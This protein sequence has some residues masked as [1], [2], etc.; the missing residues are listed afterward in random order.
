MR[1]AISQFR[2]AIQSAGL[3]P[4]DMIEPGKFHKFPG[5]GKRNGNTAAWCKLFP[6]GIG[7][8]YGDYSTGLSTDWHANRETPYTQAEREAFKRHVAEAKAQ[9]EGE[10]KAKQ[11]EAASKAATI[12]Q[13]ATP[14]DNHPYLTRKGIN[15][16]GARLH[17]D[18]LVIPMRD[19]AE[20]HSLQFI[21]PESDKRFLTGGRVQGCYFAIGKPDTVLC[22]AEGFATGASIFEATGYPVAVA[23]NAGNLEPVAKSMRGKFPDLRLIL[24]ADDDYHTVGNPGIAKAI[25]AARSVGALLAIPDFGADRPA[26]ATDF[27]DMA[28][29]CGKEAVRQAIL[30][31]RAPARTEPQPGREIPPA[32]GQHTADAETI[33]RLAALA[34]LDY[35]RVRLAEAEKLGVRVQTLDEQVKRVRGNDAVDVGGLVFAV[36]EPWHEPV[37]GERLL[38]NLAASCR[39]FIVLPPH[40]DTVL[41]LWIVFT[42]LIDAAEVAPI[43]AA[44][45]PEKRCGK[46]TLVDLLSRLVRRPMPASNISPAALFRS[47]EAWR[48]TLLID[49]ADTFV[50]ENEEL[51]GIVN[52]GHTR[53][54]A[55][56]VRT[57]GDEH[58]PKAFSTW[59]AKAIALIGRLPD[60]LDDRSIVLELRRKLPSER[61]EKLRHAEPGK[62]EFLTRQCARFAADNAARVRVARPAI[63]DDLHDRAAD[64]WEPL[65]IV[66]DVAGGEWPKRARQAASV[67][68]GA[69]ADGDSTKTELLRDV[70][71]IFERTRIERISSAGL[72]EALAADAGARWCEYNRGKPITQRQLA[73]LLRPFAIVPNSVRLDDGSTPKGYLLEDFADAFKRYTPP[74]DPQHRHKPALA[75][76][77]EE[78]ASATDSGALRIEN[79]RRSST[80]AACGGVADRNPPSGAEDGSE[81]F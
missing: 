57:V 19:G 12:W 10:R 62:F 3:I 30:G 31:A 21:T 52:S 14:A 73:R 36:V 67:L 76:V 17:N 40:G 59:S 37:N 28:S 1:D 75:R 56:V 38:D 79:T 66:A 13:G 53:P 47:V 5:E 80:G 11:A 74:F 70:R 81:V 63:P 55:F 8:I 7:G 2:D 15:A 78:N 58:E 60:T 68:S 20:L 72:A 9:A 64:N 33:A 6:D 48:P 29:H 4:P 22:I 42:H 25:E 71:A 35:D 41:A 44:V 24:C 32:A 77:S 26:K 43:L 69:T 61:V 18:A 39:R 16:S 23:F 27:N 34:P 45:S 51:R 65:L 54:T 50:R 49:E 46:T